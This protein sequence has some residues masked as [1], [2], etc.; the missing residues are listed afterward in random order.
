MRRYLLA[1]ALVAVGCGH[2]SNGSSDLSSGGGD[3]SAIVRD[4]AGGGG[5]DLAELNDGGNG[6]GDGGTCTPNGFEMCSGNNAVYCNA[7]GNGMTSVACAFGCDATNGR[8][9]DFV[10]ANQGGGNV[11]G[12]DSFTCTGTQDA[13][14]ATVTASTG[15]TLTF[16]TGAFTIKT[17]NGA[18]TTDYTTMS[19]WGAAYAPTSSGTHAVVAHIKSLSATAGAIIKVTGANA[20]VLLVDQDVTLS[21]TASTPTIV[22]LNGTIANGG[23]PGAPST[24]GAGA[25]GAAFL[26]GG[27]AGHGTAGKAGG[28]D[29]NGTAGGTAGLAYGAATVLEAGAGGANGTN[30]SG[31]GNNSAGGALQVSACGNVSIDANVVINASGGG[32]N[33]GGGVGVGGAGGNGGASGGTILLEASTF[34]APAM[35]DTVAGLLAAN[36]GGAGGGGDATNKGTAGGEWN[37]TTAVTTVATGGAGGTT[38]SG[39]GGNG[40]I[41]GTAPT[42]GGN[43]TGAANGGG[44]GGGAVGRIFLNRSPAATA[45]TAVA[46]SPAPVVGCVGTNGSAITCH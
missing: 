31:V 42:V 35:N 19:K 36:G 32:G 16:D 41:G 11:K 22:M 8:C 23:G 15:D 38:N 4:M 25:I 1:C 28:Q 17:V 13:T 12:S 45:P 46:A 21:G 7:A 40:G 2:N 37:P 20:L 27:G 29:N 18:T 33:G 26:G 34:N 43:A 3:M 5:V 44:G 30:L 39:S 9:H 24:N 14:L 10:P 6:N